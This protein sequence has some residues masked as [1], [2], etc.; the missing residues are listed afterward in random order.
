MLMTLM[1]WFY[2]FYDKHPRQADPTHLDQMILF[3]VQ[4]E[5]HVDI[6]GKSGKETRV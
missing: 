3:S 2:G 6:E 1:I 4:S 5:R